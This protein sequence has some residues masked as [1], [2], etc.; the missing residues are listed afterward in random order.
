MLL[1]LLA[2]T[3]AS[4]SAAPGHDVSLRF[5]DPVDGDTLPVGDHRVSLL[6]DGFALVQPIHNE[7]VPTGFL[8]V[9]LDDEEV[10]V[11]G[12]TVFDL[13]FPNPGEMTLSASLTY[14]DGDPLDPPVDASI[15]LLITR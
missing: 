6:V 10:L 11:T 12:A 3:V 9:R 1:F 5:L 8:V 14:A 2:C 15:G 4:D 13:T 7:G